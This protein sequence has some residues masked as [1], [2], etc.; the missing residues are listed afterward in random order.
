M[1]SKARPEAPRCRIWYSISAAISSSR[2][3]GLSSFSAAARTSPAKTPALRIC[4]ISWGSLRARNASTA[5][6]AAIHRTFL[7]A[8]ALS[9][10][11]CAT[12]SCEASNPIRDR[13]CVFSH[14][15]TE[16]VSEP[17]RSA[18][19]QEEGTRFP[20]KAAE[21]I[22]IRW[23]H[24]QQPRQTPLH[25]LRL[26]RSPS[27]LERCVHK[28][29]RGDRSLLESCLNCSLFRAC[30]AVIP[31]ITRGVRKNKSSDDEM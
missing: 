12:V 18:P 13:R 29:V 9:A 1:V 26:Q 20:A 14:A 3:P 22:P 27:L 31:G 23:V 25:H 21:V 7:P 17:H 28:T 4:A 24:D 15:P 11:S 6:L 19:Q 8:A 30:T 10:R 5:P 16:A 2:T